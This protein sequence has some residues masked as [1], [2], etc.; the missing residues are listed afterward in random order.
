MIRRSEK[1]GIYVIGTSVLAEIIWYICQNIP[2]EIKGFFDDFSKV[3][4]FQGVK[5]FGGMD[6]LS[7]NKSR[8]SDANFFIAIGDNLNRKKV[9]QRLKKDNFAL[10]NIIDPG[11]K[12]EKSAKIGEGN[13]I[14][15]NA[16]LGVKT[17]LGDC[18][19][20]FPGV[21]LNHHNK[22][23]SF[24]HLSP[25]VSIGGLTTIGSAAHIGMN[26]VIAPFVTIEDNFSCPPLTEVDKNYD[27]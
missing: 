25:N 23:G 16:Y 6:Y 21:I 12:I 22:V 7:R 24:N 9:Y 26:S 3:K 17:V 2:L 14:F 13:L 20:I 4:S 8:F 5:I 19:L 10:A 1:K 15:N 27:Q 18:N 11:A